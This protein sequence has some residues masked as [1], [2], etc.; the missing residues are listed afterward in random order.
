[1]Q[2][3]RPSD[4]RCSRRTTDNVACPQAFSKLGLCAGIGFNMWLVKQTFATRSSR[5]RH[6]FVFLAAAAAVAMGLAAGCGDEKAPAKQ[7]V[8]W[9]GLNSAPGTT[10]SSIKNF[11]LPADARAT[12]TS[13]DAVGGRIKDDADNL[14]EC[15]VRLASGS[16]TDYTVSLRF[17]GGE[18]GNFSAEGTLSAEAGGELEVNFNTGMFALEQANCVA[19]VQTLTPGAV[20]L[21]GLRCQNLRDESSPGIQCDGQG[22]LIFE[23]CDR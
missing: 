5:V 12:V 1:M 15:D 6:R 7:T 20:W 16:T 9:L 19:T 13:S 10:C 21:R 22:G 17:S 14:V 3:Q 18:V 8:F 4:G 23:N 2:P 11:Q